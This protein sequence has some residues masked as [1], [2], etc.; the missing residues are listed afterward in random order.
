[1]FK[2]R[3]GWQIKGGIWSSEWGNIECRLYLHPVE[4]QAGA[5]SSPP[6]TD[7]QLKLTFVLNITIMCR[8]CESLPVD[9][10]WDFAASSSIEVH[11]GQLFLSRRW[12]KTFPFHVLFFLCFPTFNWSSSCSW[13]AAENSSASVSPRGFKRRDGWLFSGCRSSSWTS[14]EIWLESNSSSSMFASFL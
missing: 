8:Y 3:D 2:S 6:I 5:Q 10:I 12:C 1:M 14:E 9:V 4:I 11:D 13:V 7:L